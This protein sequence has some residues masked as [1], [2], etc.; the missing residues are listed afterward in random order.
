MLTRLLS[1][2]LIF[3]ALLLGCYQ[4]AIAQNAKYGKVSEDELKMK[5]YEKD[6]TAAAVILSDIG[7][8]RFLFASKVQLITD[9]HIR[10][11]ILKKSGF[12]WA[13]FSIP[14]YQKNADKEKVTSIKGTTFNLESGAITKTKLENKAI[15]EEQR[16]ENWL[17]KKITMPNVKEGSVID[18]EYTITSDFVYTLREWEFQTT[19]PTLWSEYRAEIPE[20]FDYK[21]LMQG[22]NPL[23]KS[24]KNTRT[25]RVADP[26][27]ESPEMKKNAYV[28]CMKD[29]PALKEEKYITTLS[30]YQSKIEFELQVVRYPGQLSKTMTGDWDQVTKEL[31]ASERF[32]TQLN[33]NGY[34]KNEIA[35]I[36]AIH[37]T[38]QA[39]INAIYEL[40]K[41]QVKWNGKYGIYTNIPLRKVFETRTGSAAE[42]N[43]MLTAMLLEAG[44]DA[45]PVLISTRS[46]GRP[47]D[48]NPML[49][50][51]NYVVSLIKIDDKEVML[52]ATDPL[53]QAGMLSVRCLNGI[54]RL[55]KKTDQRWVT[56]TPSL[57]FV[58][59]FTGQVT[60]QPNGDMVGKG[61]ES[62]SG[63]TALYLRQEAQENGEN[64]LAESIGKATGNYKIGKPEIKNLGDV[65]KSLEITY[66]VTA[67]GNG[68]INDVIYL[69][70]MLGYAEKENPFKM[71]DRTY[72]VDFAAPI[73]ETFICSYVIP[74][75]YKMDEAPKDMNLVLPENSGRFMYMVQ[76]Q[77]NVIQV[78]SKIRIAKPIFYAQE[79][80]NLK[81]FYNQIVAKHAEPL[82][83]KKA[84]Q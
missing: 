33:R 45:A 19:I 74:D 25:D 49:T 29:V 21:F 53:L 12:D 75:G 15:F 56:L 6:T 69:N 78:M 57:P 76:Q 60:M 84:A 18:I 34:F 77:G 31:L 26:K 13:N 8:S 59:V 3:T 46:N 50:K 39:R 40:V 70:P 72:P 63:Y 52:D 44:F 5:Q 54:G 48:G 24:E 16:N 20:Y 30:D 82:V 36:S 61:T 58:K 41:K 68:Q 43:L 2:I 4:Q 35:A 81:E 10:I 23:Y 7:S 83:I 66:E 38:P 51:F 1:P 55:I 9:R 79:Y 62:S 47:H 22:Y 28:W 67:S 64:K 32:G 80:G 73:D 42:I 65:D 71:T 11:K 37:K 14:F 27:S 17:V